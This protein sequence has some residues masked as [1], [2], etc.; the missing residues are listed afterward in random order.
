M[1]IRK[2]TPEDLKA[3]LPHAQAAATT[4]AVEQ[5]AFT[6]AYVHLLESDASIILVAEL[7]E[8]IVGYCLGH[9]HLTFFANGR[10][11][12]LEEIFVQEAYRKT[13]VGRKLMD[14]FEEWAKS[15]DYKLIALATRRAAA[16]YKAIGFEESAVYFRKLL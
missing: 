2:A 8:E 16:F 1:K 4:F 14:A 11:S 9:Q 10:S 5:A 13:G 12:W 15:H 7:E 6:K 3:L